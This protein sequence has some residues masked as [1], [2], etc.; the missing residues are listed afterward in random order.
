[1]KRTQ[2]NRW[3]LVYSLWNF[4]FQYFS[5]GSVAIKIRINTPLL[6]FSCNAWMPKLLFARCGTGGKLGP[7]DND[8][9]GPTT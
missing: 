2:A 7:L 6:V 5:V 4:P 8:K 3:V 1:M 9:E